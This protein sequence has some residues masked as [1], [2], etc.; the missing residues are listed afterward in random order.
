MILTIKNQTAGTRSYLSGLVTVADSSQTVLPRDLNV[1]IVSDA[2]FISD[3]INSVVILNN[4]VNDLNPGRGLDLIQF[5]GNFSTDPIA[6]LFLYYSAVVNIRQTAASDVG[7]IVWSMR[8][9]L[10]STLNV[11]IERMF[12][13]MSFDAL[14][15]LASKLLRYEFVR[16]NTATPSG[17]TQLTPIKASNLAPASAVDVR[18]LDIGL[19]TTSVVF[20]NPFGTILCPAVQG[21]VS[22]YDRSGI[23]L[24]LAPGEGLAIR[25]AGVAASVGQGISGEITWSLR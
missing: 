12:L 3:V 17:G 7:T 9:P 6:S 18:Y 16:F 21:A 1:I 13:Q 4:G 10:A 14:T 22:T 19:T 8:N 5:L 23:V 20:E 11:A 15:P 24:K 2:Q 25:V